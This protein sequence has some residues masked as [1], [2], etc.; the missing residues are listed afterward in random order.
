MNKVKF[1]VLLALMLVGFRYASAQ[2][3]NLNNPSRDI[4]IPVYVYEGY[5]PF[6]GEKVDVKMV[7]YIPG[8]P[9][10]V[11]DYETLTTDKNGKATTTWY[12]DDDAIIPIYNSYLLFIVR[13]QTKAWYTIKD[14]P[15]QFNFKQVTITKPDY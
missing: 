8:G 11:T 12:V 15:V 10:T 13:G 2:A 7:R 4:I 1:I 9:E 5:L 14:S 3:L 6:S